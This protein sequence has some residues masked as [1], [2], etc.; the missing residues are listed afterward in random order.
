MTD[1]NQDDPSTI[2]DPFIDPVRDRVPCD[3][4]Q[5]DTVA[6]KKPAK[7]KRRKPGK[8]INVKDR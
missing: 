3:R 7:P 2:V 1:E 8:R 6:G 4:G 5:D